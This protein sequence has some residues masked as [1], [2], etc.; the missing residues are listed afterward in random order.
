[1]LRT[2][3]LPTSSSAKPECMKKT[4]APPTRSHIQSIEEFAALMEASRPSMAVTA[5]TNVAW[6]VAAS[7]GSAL[8][9]RFRDAARGTAAEVSSCQLT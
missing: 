1:M 5:A 2:E 7:C 9:V 8:R 4:S 6:V 3:T